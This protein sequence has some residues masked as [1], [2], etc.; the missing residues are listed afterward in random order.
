MTSDLRVAVIA[1][2]VEERW[3]SMD[4]VAE[5]LMANAG[6]NGRPISPV[7][8]RP[9]F[10]KVGSLGRNGSVREL[11]T[12]QRIAQRFWSYP[13]WLRRQPP[14]D[15]YHIVDHTYAHLAHELP[16]QRVVVTCH[17][18]DA[19]RTLLMPSRRESNLPRLFVKRVLSGLRRAAAVVCDTEATR[20]DLVRHSL[21]D[22][23]RTV[24]VPIG[25]HPTCTTTPDRDADAAAAAMTGQEGGL[26]LLH[27][28]ST[29][30]RKR[31]D[32]VL[33]MLALIARERPDV[34]LWRVGGPFTEAQ[35]RLARQLGV[36][37]RISVLPFVTRPV[38]AALYRRAALVLLPS[39]REGFGLPVIEAMACG[40]PV[41]C[42]D[43]PVLREVGGDAAEYCPSG[44]PHAWAAA[45]L[46]LLAERES[47]RG[48]WERRCATGVARAAEFSWMRHAS[49]M[50][51][52]YQQVAN[53][54]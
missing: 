52:M 33:N 19:F 27:V 36:D 31:I 38:L 32:V 13:R 8:F 48:R 24:V 3:P 17:D 34:R 47:V 42:T 20:A 26:H 29:V 46:S 53:D 35:A 25:V 6:R 11:P 40:T 54:V 28:G 1:D 45:V 14:A 44:Q 18:I 23:A 12:I 50:E 21:V 10:G 51:R 39:D 16:S 49:S 7:L 2:L 15:V 30:P 9:S 41:V 43:L 5:M 37:G 22:P 4:L